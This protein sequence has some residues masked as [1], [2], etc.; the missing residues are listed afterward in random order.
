MIAGTTLN[1]QYQ[2]RYTFRLKTRYHKRVYA[3]TGKVC[4]V[5]GSQQLQLATIDRVLRTRLF[6]TDGSV[7]LVPGSQQ[8]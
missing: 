6:A 1:S 2:Q 7:Y 4:L 8:R 5:H 3:T